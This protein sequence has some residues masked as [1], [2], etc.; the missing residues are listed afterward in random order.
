MSVA[1]TEI[2]PILE[3]RGVCLP[4]FDIAGG[5]GDF[6][7]GILGACEAARAPALLLVY[8]SSDPYIDLAACAELVGSVADRASV[9]VVLHLDHARSEEQV[10]AALDAGFR[11]V[12]FDASAC[13]LEENIRRTKKMAEVA[14]ARGASI[15]G[16]VG[17][18]GATVG[19]EGI[20]DPDEAGR[21]VRET[22]VDIFA[23]A[24][25][26]AHGFYR[27]PPEL[28]FDV[29]ERIAESTNVPLSL[30]GGTGLPPADVCRAAELGV[31][32]MNVATGIHRLFGTALR[33]AVEDAEAES[34]RWPKALG[35]A[36]AAVGA[37]AARYLRELGAED[38]VQ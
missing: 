37:A 4:G 20:T 18:I 3:E 14:H 34:F 1:L 2:L 16:E 19:E 33:K 13:P 32:K 26:N 10:Q 15:E 27:E 35:A 9:P 23:P 11:S 21:F 31:R 25:G 28:Q 7:M 38:L 24:V 22:G 6:L 8:A 12:M 36:R 30:H 17:R 5:Q 29:I